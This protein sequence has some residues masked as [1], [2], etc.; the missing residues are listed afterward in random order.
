MTYAIASTAEIE[1]AYHYLEGHAPSPKYAAVVR[2]IRRCWRK[3]GKATPPIL[4]IAAR[5]GVSP[6]TVKRATRWIQSI[7]M[8]TVVARRPHV[9][10]GRWHR[11]QTN[12]YVIHWPRRPRSE[13]GVR[14]DPSMSY[15]S[16]GTPPGVSL[17]SVPEID[18][19]DPPPTPGRE[20]LAQYTVIRDGVYIRADLVE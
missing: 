13:L 8:A 7:G 16:V 18:P 11:T 5:T 1:R 15:R 2:E 19:P 14:P 6:S 3:F 4:G 12:L 9:R 17:T 20:H 10:E